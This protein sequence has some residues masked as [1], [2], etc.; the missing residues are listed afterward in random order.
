MALISRHLTGV[1]VAAVAAA[2]LPSLAASQT[3]SA[4]EAR[5]RLEADR[6]KLEATQKR[7]KEVQADAGQ[8]RR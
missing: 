4:E 7:S 8:D 3:P 6:G 1:F 5:K 2:A